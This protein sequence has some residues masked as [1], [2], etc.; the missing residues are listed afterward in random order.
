ME[1]GSR[2]HVADVSSSGFGHEPHPVLP[3]RHY[4]PRSAPV[5][6]GRRGL[7]LVAGGGSTTW[8]A[9][10]AATRSPTPAG[11]VSRDASRYPRCPRSARGSTG[12]GSGPAAGAAR[13]GGQSAARLVRSLI[14]APAAHDPSRCHRLLASPAPPRPGAATGLRSSPD[15][16]PISARSPAWPCLFLRETTKIA[17]HDPISGGLLEPRRRGAP[18]TGAYRCPS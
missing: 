18:T 4:R 8:P 16:P 10:R 11:M 17:L 5:H 6:R 12:R 14:L 3:Q 2:R 15:R 7:A 1:S 13:P 9:Q